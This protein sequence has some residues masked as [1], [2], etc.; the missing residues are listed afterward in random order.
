MKSSVFKIFLNDITTFKQK[1]APDQLNTELAQ[2]II[3][4]SELNFFENPLIGH[5]IKENTIPEEYSLY[6]VDGTRY[7]QTENPLYAIILIAWCKITYNKEQTSNFSYELIPSFHIPTSS[8]NA[9]TEIRE[10]QLSYEEDLANK[11]AKHND[12]NFVLIDGSITKTVLQ[13]SVMTVTSSPAHKTINHHYKD[14]ALFKMILKPY[15]RSCWIENT[16][17][18]N[19]YYTYINN[20][21]DVLRIETYAQEKDYRDTM[22]GILK[23]SIFASHGY[24]HILHYAHCLTRSIKTYKDVAFYHIKEELRTK[25]ILKK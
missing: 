21:Y 11:F 16:Y 17:T 9:E 1:N 18:K 5:Q 15:E 14:S 8:Y 19:M 25:N 24:P 13:K 10:L 23:K 2:K 4:E 6:G 7:I 20:G 12:Y 22:V 3:K